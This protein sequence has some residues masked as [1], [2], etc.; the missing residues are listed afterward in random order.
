[1]TKYQVS[2][3]TVPGAISARYGV[4]VKYDDQSPHDD[5]QLVRRIS[6]GEPILYDTYSGAYGWIRRNVYGYTPARLYHAGYRIHDDTMLDGPRAVQTRHVTFRG[7]VISSGHK[8]LA[9][10]VAAANEHE[11]T[12]LP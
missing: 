9:D 12:R 4:R 8:T 7:A 5:G 10:A 3:V 6:N 2:R 1:M 11:R